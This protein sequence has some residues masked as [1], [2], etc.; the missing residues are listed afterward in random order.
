MGLDGGFNP[1][2]VFLL[3]WTSSSALSMSDSR[4]DP[5]QTA[6]TLKC[7]QNQTGLQPGGREKESN[8]S[9][10]TH[11][12]L[13]PP[14]FLFLPLWVVDGIIEC[15][16]KGNDAFVELFV[17]LLILELVNVTTLPRRL[18]LLV[19]VGEHVHEHCRF[20]FICGGFSEA[21][22]SYVLNVL[23]SCNLSF[24]TLHQ[25]ICCRR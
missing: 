22:L 10:R 9:A 18:K 24:L 11:V 6:N 8:T 25:I 20:V 19:H 21:A 4:K 17:N 15:T 3:A 14:L 7:S 12:N 13:L 23:A 16:S 1:T 2:L 5:A